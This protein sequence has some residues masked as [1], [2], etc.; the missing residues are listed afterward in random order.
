MPRS[1]IVSYGQDCAGPCGAGVTNAIRIAPWGAWDECSCCRCH[2]EPAGQ[3]PSGVS[4]SLTAVERPW[5][6]RRMRPVAPLPRVKVNRSSLNPLAPFTPETV[7]GLKVLCAGGSYHNRPWPHHEKKCLLEVY[8]SRAD[9]PRFFLFGGRRAASCSLK[10]LLLAS[11]PGYATSSPY[12]A[13]P[14]LR[15]LA[16]T[17]RHRE[18][19]KKRGYR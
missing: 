17:G 11:P 12:F 15:G 4:R 5:L 3:Y 10:K 14:S 13:V 8:G 6:H 18:A 19:R 7:K 9:R 1:R 16:G 2:A